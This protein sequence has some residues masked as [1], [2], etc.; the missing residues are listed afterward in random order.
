MSESDIKLSIDADI[1]EKALTEA[2][3]NALKEVNSKEGVVKTEDSI[4]RIDEAPVNQILEFFKRV[5][6]NYVTKKQELEIKKAKLRLNTDWKKELPNI[7]R[8]TVDDKEAFILTQIYE[9]KQ[10]LNQLKVNRDYLWEL[11]KLK[12][13]ILSVEASD[14]Y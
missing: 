11:F 8:P 10:R 14:K 9:D 4:I 1:D 6:S 13:L 7:S 2:V 12:K 5:D 3:T